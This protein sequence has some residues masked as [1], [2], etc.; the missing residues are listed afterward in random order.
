MCFI[1]L[2]KKNTDVYNYSIGALLLE[3]RQRLG[4]GDERAAANYRRK[5]KQVRA[6]RHCRHQSGKSHRCFAFHEFRISSF[7]SIFMSLFRFRCRKCF[8][9][10][11]HRRDHQVRAQ[12]EVVYSRRRG[13]SSQILLI[14]LFTA[15]TSP[16]LHSHNHTCRSTNTTCIKKGPSSTLSRRC[17][18]RWVS[19][20][21]T[22]SSPH[23]CR[24][25]RASWASEC[26]LVCCRLC[27]GCEGSGFAGAVSEVATARQSTWTLMCSRNS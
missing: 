20:T 21:P 6:P 8:D 3:R 22:W 17:S 15:A 13:Q 14:L 27:F 26:P 5:P 18:W 19:P 2:R 9:S 24:H 16:D 4:A 23:S 12:R 10:Q 1:K 25:P 11:K 7:E